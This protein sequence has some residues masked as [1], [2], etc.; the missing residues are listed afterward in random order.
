MS[1]RTPD[2]PRDAAP[3][4]RRVTA[5]PFHRIVP[6]LLRDPLKALGD[7]ATAA[8][9]DIVRLNLGTF[10]P[11]LITHPDHVQH[12]LRANAANYRRAGAF[13]DPFRPLFGKGVLSDGENWALS[14][15]ALNGNFT[16]KHV[17][18]MAESMAEI[19]ADAIERLD[20]PAFLGESVDISDALAAI[21]SKTITELFFGGRIT[22]EE[23]ERLIPV[24]GTIANTIVFR[25]MLPAVPKAFPLPGD[26]GFRQAV[27]TF[28]SVMNPLVARYPTAPEGDDVFAAL[29]RA[30][31]ASGGRLDDR[32]VRDNMVA[33]YAA[34][35][36]TTIM[37]LTWLWP[38]LAEHPH[39]EE[40]LMEEAHRVVGDGRVTPA[41]L[42]DL[43]YTKM[44]VQE[45]LR[46][47]PVGWLFPRSVVEPETL[48]GAELKPGDNVLFSPYLTHRLPS[49]WDR[50][51]EFD[52]ERFAPERARR[53][54]R[55]AYFP[56]GGG[57]H[58][59][60]GMHVFNMEAV[61]IVAG[62]MARY[63]P[64][65]ATAAKVTPRAAVTLRPNVNVEVRL[66]PRPRA[67]AIA[68]GIR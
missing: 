19:I 45:V 12:V 54:H 24:E 53:R 56:F 26:R 59:C 40:R 33:T 47:Y 21:I 46:L 29:C 4:G 20:G 8:D 3:R 68:E 14:R 7:I 50:P 5:H 31:D 23:S 44:V 32:W 41:H 38:L 10:R 64:R 18:S 2:Q 49:V 55:Y 11:Y 48:G 36:E 34:G 17:E 43:V 35:T 13:W 67:G 61:F 22:Y 63:R 16:A 52:P 42:P 65:L 6:R 37:A 58:Q 66:V 39:V 9:G 60:I 28:D 57:P 25:I 30:R 15:Q 27:E 51:L 1:S 62:L